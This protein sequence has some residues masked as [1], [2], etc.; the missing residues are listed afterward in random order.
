MK[1]KW[2]SAQI[3]EFKRCG[4][5]NE[6]DYNLAW[7]AHILY[8]EEKTRHSITLPRRDF[9]KTI[10]EWEHRNKEEKTERTF[11]V[12]ALLGGKKTGQKI[13]TVGQMITTHDG[14]DF[15]PTEFLK[16]W[17]N[18]GIPAN[19]HY[20]QEMTGM[21]DVLTGGIHIDPAKFKKEHFPDID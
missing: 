3:N 15:N 9:V 1:N 8:K 7:Q 6:S 19:I 5:E 21:E 11:W 12:T 2:T 14:E 20:V 13:I 16:M 17:D 18:V 4:A 10:M